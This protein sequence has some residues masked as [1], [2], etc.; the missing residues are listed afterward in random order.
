M[1]SI[2]P[3]S[4]PSSLDP[5]LIPPALIPLNSTNQKVT[6]IFQGKEENVEESSEKLVI[7]NKRDYIDRMQLNLT[8]AIYSNNI[9]SIITILESQ[10]QFLNKD[11]RTYPR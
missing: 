2:P 5:A 10:V 7:E 8:N 6:R 4:T 3:I 11:N 9:Q 1:S